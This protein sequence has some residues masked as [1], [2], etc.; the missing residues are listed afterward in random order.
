MQK[1]RCGKINRWVIAVAGVIMQICLGTVYGWSVFTI[2]LESINKWDRTEV[3]LAFTIAIGAVGLSAALGGML[4]NKVSPRIISTIGGVLF[5]TG[6][7]LTGISSSIGSLVLMYMAYGVIGGT[8]IGLGYVTPVSVLVKWFPEKRGL[9]TGIAIMGFGFGA[10]FM[11][12]F[13]PGLIDSIGVSP[14]FYLLGFIFF[15]LI[16]AASRYMIN[17]APDFKPVAWDKKE[18]NSAAGITLKDAL[19]K[20]EFW[21]FWLILFINIS[22]GIALISQASPMVQDIY[23]RTAIQAGVIIGVFSLFNGFGRLFWSGISDIIGRKTVFLILFASQ[24][25]VFFI[26]PHVNSLA[27]F[28]I[29]ACYIYACYGGG[30][31]TMPAFAADVF[32]TKHIGAIY[33]WIL[34]AW[35]AAGVAGPILYSKVRQ[36]TQS[37]SQALIITSISLLISLVLPVLVKKNKA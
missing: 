9:I 7:V 6:M 26:I 25:I 30:F 4:L 5:G 10:F 32:G 37:Y 35:S 24:A 13:T 2:P 31:A 29:L 33:G 21:L 18:E 1:N 19:K 17:P 8:G 12:A 11:S 36:I 23:G 14:T 27:G 20:K 34:T 22:A 3:T 15:A 28:I 16:L